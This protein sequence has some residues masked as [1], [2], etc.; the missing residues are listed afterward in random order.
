MVFGASTMQ[1]Q[2]VIVMSTTRGESALCFEQ[3]HTHFTSYIC[4]LTT[5]CNFCIWINNSPA[6]LG[7]TFSFLNVSLSI[8]IFQCYHTSSVLRSFDVIFYHGFLQYHWWCHTLVGILCTDNLPPW[9][10]YTPIVKVT[11]PNVFQE[12]VHLN[13]SQDKLY[14]SSLSIFKCCQS[15]S[16]CLPVVLSNEGI[17]WSLAR[18]TLCFWDD[19]YYETSF[20]FG[21]SIF[22]RFWGNKVVHGWVNLFMTHWQNVGDTGAFTH[23][24][25]PLVQPGGGWSGQG[26]VWFWE[27]TI[28]WPQIAHRYLILFLLF[29]LLRLADLG[30]SLCVCNWHSQ[31]WQCPF[32]PQ[33]SPEPQAVWVCFLWTQPFYICGIDNLLK[34]LHHFF[35]QFPVT[36]DRDHLVVKI[37][38]CWCHQRSNHVFS[39]HIIN[40]SRS[41]FLR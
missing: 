21:L 2:L 35:M 5:P 7:Y 26:V 30:F 36:Q 9:M 10:M 12:E 40:V 39:S 23:L 18:N 24:F 19:W 1:Q 17:Y 34:W 14:S 25:P 20:I 3:L 29:P 6:M 32:N 16:V 38:S 41:F 4:D 22:P 27:P 37:K 13:V 33:L 15:F 28:L 11:A 8:Y 31:G